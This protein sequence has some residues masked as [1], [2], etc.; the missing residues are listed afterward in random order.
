MAQDASGEQSLP[1]HLGPRTPVPPPH[2]KLLR[3]PH[4]RRGQEAAEHPGGS[5]WSFLIQVMMTQDR[6][7]YTKLSAQHH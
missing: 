6:C 4:P 5:W 7:V 3:M 1:S 2:P